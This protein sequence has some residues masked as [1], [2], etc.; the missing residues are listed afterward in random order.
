MDFGIKRRETAF[1]FPTNDNNS[2]LLFAVQ[3]PSGH[4][5]F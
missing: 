1:L 4:G 5:S 2:N 3:F